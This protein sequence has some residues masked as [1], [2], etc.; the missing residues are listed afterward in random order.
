MYLVLILA[1]TTLIF[2]ITTLY[3]SFKRKV[4]IKKE[5]VTEIDPEL[6]NELAGYEHTLRSIAYDAKSI[7]EARKLADDAI[8]DEK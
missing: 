5:T 3:F 1:T 7:K 2:F 6:E 8:G 4:I